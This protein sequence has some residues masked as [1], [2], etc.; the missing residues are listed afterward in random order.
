MLGCVHY[1]CPAQML[2]AS[3]GETGHLSPL[4][5]PKLRVGIEGTDLPCE[6]RTGRMDR[7]TDPLCAMQLALC[8]TLSLEIIHV[9][10]ISLAAS[11]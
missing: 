9:C 4:A 6:A 7:S 3:Q 1:L 11:P 2:P 10:V 5:K 8:S